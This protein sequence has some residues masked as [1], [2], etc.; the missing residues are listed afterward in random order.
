LIASGLRENPMV[1]ENQF[2]MELISESERD[3]AVVAV[4]EEEEEEDMWPHTRTQTNK[5]NTKVCSC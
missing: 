2:E 5:Q 3:N 4:E 1:F